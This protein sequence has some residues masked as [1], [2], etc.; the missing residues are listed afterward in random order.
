MIMDEKIA[1]WQQAK[2]EAAAAK[3]RL[4]KITNEIASEMLLNETK[5][6]VVLV[7][8]HLQKVTVVQSETVKFDE[9]SLYKA[10]GKRQFDKIADLKLN[11]KKLEAAIRDGIVDPELVS[12][13]AIIS[14]STPY[15]R[16][17]D[18]TGDED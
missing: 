10:M 16:V 7:D 14:K 9:D 12:R 6:Y 4:D 18:Y 8:G 15:I 2:E 5:S 3:E 13:N 11:K 1:E 17:S